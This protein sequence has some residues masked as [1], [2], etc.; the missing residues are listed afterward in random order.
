MR[1][2]AADATQKRPQSKNIQ[3]V[4]EG[5]SPHDRS[6]I[7][8]GCGRCWHTSLKVLVLSLLVA[9]GIW[10]FRVR[11]NSSRCGTPA[12]FSLLVAM[13]MLPLLTAV[14]PQPA[15][16]FADSAGMPCCQIVSKNPWQP[17]N[18][19]RPLHPEPEASA[20][21]SQPRVG[22]D[23]PVVGRRETPSFQRESEFDSRPS[24]VARTRPTSAGL[25]QRS[26]IENW[27]RQ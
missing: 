16:A 19:R 1:S 6:R 5:G 26:S 3:F 24:D 12:W 25:V 17:S 11:S 4:L 10:I 21:P 22:I 15:V 23:Q 9:A 13:W 8:L 18:Q 2:A 27:P 20:E 7:P 14:L